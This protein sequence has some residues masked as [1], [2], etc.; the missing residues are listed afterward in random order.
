MGTV[1]KVKIG[2]LEGNVRAG[3]LIRTRKE[4]TGVV[5]GIYWKKRFLVSFHNR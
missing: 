2:D 5:Q 3:C 4:L 1:V